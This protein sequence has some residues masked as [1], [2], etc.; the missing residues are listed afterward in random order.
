MNN[1]AVNKESE[2]KENNKGIVTLMQND[3]MGT[4]LVTE[5]VIASIASIAAA[6]VEGVS[7]VITNVPKELMSRV[8]AQK[9]TKAVKVKVSD[10]QVVIYI[11][12]TMDY[13]YNIPATC[14]NVQSRVK[15]AIENMTGLTCTDVNIRIMNIKVK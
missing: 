15:S 9:M 11:A 2:K 13:G 1:Q 6:E 8:G 5:D 7:A 14:R 3:K 12:I 4:V 10:N